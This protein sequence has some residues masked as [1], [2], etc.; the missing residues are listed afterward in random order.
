M[1]ANPGRVVLLRA[2]GNLG[3]PDFAQAIGADHFDSMYLGGDVVNH[4]NCSGNFSN[5]EIAGSL[6]STIGCYNIMKDV[7][8]LGP[9]DPNSFCGVSV[10]LGGTTEGEFTCHSLDVV[11]LATVKRAADVTIH[12]PITYLNMLEFEGSANMLVDWSVLSLYIGNLET[13][14]L[15]LLKLGAPAGGT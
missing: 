9:G 6:R 8:V 2:N 14:Y 4:I 1:N 13:P 15:F 10:D 12:A 11:S 3:H 7:R 5:V